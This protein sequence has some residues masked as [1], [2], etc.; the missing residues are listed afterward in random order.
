MK[1]TN[2]MHKHYWLKPF[3]DVQLSSPTRRVNSPPLLACRGFSTYHNIKNKNNMAYIKNWKI[4][5]GE[6]YKT[7]LQRIPSVTSY[8][9]FKM[10]T[11]STTALLHLSFWRYYFLSYYFFFTFH[12][13]AE[14]QLCH[15]KIKL[16]TKVTK[17]RACCEMFSNE[18]QR[19]KERKKRIGGERER[20]EREREREAERK[21]VLPTT[22]YN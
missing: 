3:P 11:H 17:E 16:Y 18:S 4:I 15:Q 7:Y 8:K 1:I 14:I 20:R 22:V 9:S 19:E 21:R 12:E 6:K 13:P 2:G 5:I 10:V